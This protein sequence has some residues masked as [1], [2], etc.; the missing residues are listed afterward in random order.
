MLA[1]AS[2]EQR[3]IRTHGYHALDMTHTW[4][5]LALR[6]TK[7]CNLERVTADFGHVT[8][9]IIGQKVLRTQHRNWLGLC[10]LP[11]GGLQR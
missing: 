8:A 2:S 11:R 1:A 6:K 7:C 3:D 10:R 4:R 9:N 5:W